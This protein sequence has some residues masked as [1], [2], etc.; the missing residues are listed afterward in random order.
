MSHYYSK[1]IIRSI[2]TRKLNYI[3]DEYYSFEASS[4]MSL[5]WVER[6][7]IWAKIPHQQH[8]HLREEMGS[9]FTANAGKSSWLK[10]TLSTSSCKT[11]EHVINNNIK[12]KFHMISYLIVYAL[13]YHGCQC[14][15]KMKMSKAEIPRYI[16]SS[17]DSWF[18]L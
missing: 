4:W 5:I 6:E 1:Q 8:L 10:Y 3:G 17:T 13:E 14:I 7:Q 18:D 2:W 9:K 16:I 12:C 15:Y 11:L